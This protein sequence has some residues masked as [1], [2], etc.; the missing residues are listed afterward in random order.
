[1]RGAITDGYVLRFE[2][3]PVEVVAEGSPHAEPARGRRRVRLLDV[4]PRGGRRVARARHRRRRHGGV[5]GPLQRDWHRARR[6]TLYFVADGSIWSID[7]AS[8]GGKAAVLVPGAGSALLAQNGTSLFWAHADAKSTLRAA[9]KSDGVT[10]ELA[11]A[12]D[13]PNGVA[14]DGDF[15]FFTTMT[16]DGRVGRVD[17]GHP[18]R[19]R[20]SR[21][22]RPRPRRSRSTVPGSGSRTSRAAPSS[23]SSPSAARRPSRS[24]PVRTT[25][26]ASRSTPTTCT[27]STTR[28]TARSSACRAPP[29]RRAHG[30][31]PPLPIPPPWPAPSCARRPKYPLRSGRRPRRLR[32]SRRRAPSS[33]RSA[34]GARAGRGRRSRLSASAYAM[35]AVAFARFPSSMPSAP[36]V[37]ACVADRGVPSIASRQVTLMPYGFRRVGSVASHGRRIRASSSRRARGSAGD[38]RRVGRVL[39]PEELLDFKY[40]GR[41]SLMRMLRAATSTVSAKRPSK[42]RA[43]SSSL[44]RE[45]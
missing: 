41:T 29:S 33:G 11:T 16:A 15:V 4:D 45:T 35:I 28:T 26:S 3:G 24:P 9:R 18:G 14:A 19:S 25:P 21:R 31:A 30:I 20:G 43:A 6:A 17:V 44:S 27:G 5:D 8:E 34:P 32:S 38:L 36:S 2:G 23:A 22:S 12:I 7:V 1:M 37:V 13:H 42:M 10:T 39:L 40:G